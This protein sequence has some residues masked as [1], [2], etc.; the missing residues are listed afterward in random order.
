[1]DYVK[2]RVVD[3]AEGRKAAYERLQFALQAEKDP[4]LERAK[5]GVAKHE[6]EVLTV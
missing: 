4:W 5:E 3:D 2:Q 6:F 1:M